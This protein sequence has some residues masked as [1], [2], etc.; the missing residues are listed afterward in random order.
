[1]E[2][3]SLIS[4]AIA[5]V[6]LF[7]MFYIFY[8]HKKIRKAIVIS[9]VFWGLIIVFYYYQVFM[10]IFWEPPFEYI[11]KKARQSGMSEGNISKT[12]YGPAGSA[13]GEYEN[14]MYNWRV[15][16]ECIFDCS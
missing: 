9:S 15:F 5:I 8:K 4:N 12:I 1:M 6:V 11:E 10:A 16:G 3:D 2:P 14:W 7:S 13:I